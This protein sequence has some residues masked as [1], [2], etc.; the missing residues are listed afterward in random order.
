[1]AATIEMLKGLRAGYEAHHAVAIT[2][3]AIVAAATLADRYVSDRFLPDKAIDLI[4]EAGARIRIRRLTEDSTVDAEVGPD[5]VADVLASWTGIPVTRLTEAETTRLL[6]MED[7]LHKQIVGQEPAV[8]TVSQAIRR[9]RAAWPT[10]SDRAGSFIFAGPSGVGKSELAKTLAEFLFGTPDAL[11]QL[12]MSKYHERH[13]VARLVRARPVT[14]GTT[15][16]ASSPSGC[17]GAR[18]R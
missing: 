14:S 15:R 16:V 3:A 7:E 6:T 2:D 11:I 8:T 13:S 17:A 5:E 12:D 9:T 18:S 1:M 10:P 4:D